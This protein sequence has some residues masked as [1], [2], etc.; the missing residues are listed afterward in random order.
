MTIV[1]RGEVAHDRKRPEARAVAGPIDRFARGSFNGESMRIAKGGFVVAAFAF[2][3]TMDA[4]ATA[5]NVTKTGRG[6]EGVRLYEDR[7]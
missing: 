5:G 2:T 7:E 4:A 1:Y 6:H 3:A